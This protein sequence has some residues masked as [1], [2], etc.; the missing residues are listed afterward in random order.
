MPSNQS[1]LRAAFTKAEQG[2]QQA[3]AT[4]NEARTALCA[5]GGDAFMRDV[6]VPLQFSS[7]GTTQP[8]P[9]AVKTDC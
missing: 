6:R 5:A 4:Y 9:S 1:D 2:L 3:I 8:A 7:S